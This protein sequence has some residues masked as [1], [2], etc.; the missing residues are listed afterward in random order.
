MAARNGPTLAAAF[1]IFSAPA[2][3]GIELPPAEF[4]GAPLETALRERRSVREFSTKPLALS[5]VS[6]LLW[7]GQGITHRDGLRTAPS[8]GALYPLELRLVVGHVEDLD[9]GIYHYRPRRH[10]LEPVVAGDQRVAVASA[11]LEQGWVA[12][13]P[14]IVVLS[15][16]PERT[17][18]KYGER[19]TRYVHIEAGHAAQ[20]MCL[21]AASLGLGA[22]VVGAFDD[23]R[24]ARLLRL[25]EVEIPILIIPVGRP[26]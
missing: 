13:A 19:A 24:L 22:T 12:T 23:D 8:A 11:A 7:A 18:K 21:Q 6:Q 9:V 20:N 10:A 17:G 4:K 3:G 26:E 15:A 14:A 25:P 1:A 2:D 5:H 16:V